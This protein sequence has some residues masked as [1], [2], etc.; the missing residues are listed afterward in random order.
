MNAYYFRKDKIAVLG[1]IKAQLPFSGRK[2]QLLFSWNEIPFPTIFYCLNFQLPHPRTD[3]I[4]LARR[5]V[6]LKG[7]KRIRESRKLHSKPFTYFFSLG[8]PE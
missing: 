8:A 6:P 1:V 7:H 4:V 3:Q 2:Y 5:N